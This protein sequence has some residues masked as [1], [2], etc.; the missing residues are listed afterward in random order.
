MIGQ[1][2]RQGVIDLGKK[3]IAI[4]DGVLAIGDWDNSLFLKTSASKLKKLREQAQQLCVGEEDITA[5]D[6]NKEFYQ[7]CVL[8]GHS[9]VFILLYQVDGANLQTWL[10]TI[11][12]L[13]EYSVTRPAYKDVVHVQGAIRSK[14]SPLDHSAYVVVNVKDDAFQPGE[15]Q[16]DSLGH[17]LVSL[18]E[19]AVKLENIVEFVHGNK[20]RYAIR[21]NKLVFLGEI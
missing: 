21:D 14:S 18:S 1:D 4:L 7:E 10:G 12:N 5:N 3:L 2:Q 15:Q 17:P 13:T 9:Q 20:K 16:M 8:P 19:D 11:K 6:D